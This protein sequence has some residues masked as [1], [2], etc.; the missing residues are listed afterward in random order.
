MAETLHR[1][2][3]DLDTAGMANN[4]QKCQ[5]CNKVL[6]PIDRVWHCV[7]RLDHYLICDDCHE[8]AIIH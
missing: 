2:P 7:A 6:D 3:K 4:L 5:W 8:K 1:Q